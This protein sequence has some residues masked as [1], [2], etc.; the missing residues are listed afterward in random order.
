MLVVAEG[1][2]GVS[3]RRA[4]GGDQAGGK[5]GSDQSCG[6]EREDDW[7]TR[8]FVDPM[9]SEFAKSKADDQ[10]EEQAAAYAACCGRENQPEYIGRSCAEGHANAEFV[11]ARGDGVGDDAVEADDGERERKGGENSEQCGDEALR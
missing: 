4:P 2:H 5:G 3:R 10:T 9:R 8:R 6:Y 1:S 7:V 11:G